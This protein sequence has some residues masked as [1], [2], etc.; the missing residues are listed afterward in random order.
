VLLDDIRVTKD[1]ARTSAALRMLTESWEDVK[2]KTRGKVLCVR[3]SRSSRCDSTC[4]R[5]LRSFPERQIAA[6]CRSHDVSLFVLET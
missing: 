2:R 6:S 1:L 3:E 4:S 5:I